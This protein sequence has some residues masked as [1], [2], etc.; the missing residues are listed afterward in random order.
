MTR[1][2]IFVHI[3]TEH[4]SGC[5]NPVRLVIRATELYTMALNIFSIIIAAAD[6]CDVHI[7]PELWLIY[8]S[9]LHVTLLAC[10]IWRW[11]PCLG[12][13]RI[14]AW[15]IRINLKVSFVSREPNLA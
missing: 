15:V 1:H 4:W 11:L 13:M 6:N 10:I 12:Y 9:L 2:Y 8:M 3:S 5:T 7:T 14:V